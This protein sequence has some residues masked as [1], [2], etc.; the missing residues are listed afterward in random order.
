MLYDMLY[1]EIAN[2]R[3]SIMLKTANK[4]LVVKRKVKQRVSF[5]RDFDRFNNKYIFCYSI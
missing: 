4:S 2:V 3:T 5:R 1:E